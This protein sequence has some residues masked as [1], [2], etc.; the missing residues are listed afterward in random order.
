[1][2]VV[3]VVKMGFILTSLGDEKRATFPVPRLLIITQD[4]TVWTE[5]QENVGIYANT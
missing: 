5:F 4:A 2:K 3:R 1:M